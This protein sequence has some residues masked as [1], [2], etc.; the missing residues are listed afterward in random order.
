[1]GW[2]GTR[3]IGVALAITVAL[4]LT[5]PS[6][7]AEEIIVSDR[8]ALDAAKPAVP[9][10]L[11][12]P[13]EPEDEEVVLSE[14]GVIA[15]S[16]LYPAQFVDSGE[17]TEDFVDSP[18]ACGG[19]CCEPGCCPV[20]CKPSPGLIQF[21][22]HHSGARWTG[23]VEA[24]LLWRNAPANRAIFSEWNPETKTRGDSVIGAGD[25]ESTPAAGP[26]ISLFRHDCSGHTAEFTYF[27]AFNF[28]AQE[29]TAPSF[30]GYTIGPKG[31]Y[32]NKWT[33]LD[34][35]TVNLGSGLQSFEVN[36]RKCWTENVTLLAGLR[37]FEW[38][39]SVNILD[40]F[41]DPKLGFEDDLYNTRTMNSLYGGQIGFDA[42]LW[43]RGNWL[44]VDGLMKGGAYY[45]LATQ[46]SS[47]Q[48]G[49]TGT[50]SYAGRTGNQMDQAAFL[51]EVGLT[52]TIP[53]T[54]HVAFT[55]GYLGLWIEG[56]AQP[57]NQLSGQRIQ[58]VN[59]PP[60]KGSISAT[61]GTVVQGVTLGLNA[62]W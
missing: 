9:A 47:Y 8:P 29:A 44:R 3:T 14:D 5:G 18:H 6:A 53:L 31:I 36:E 26:R 38:R 50:P 54:D 23:R 30:G 42:R 34:A 57:T 1:M 25:L 40:R 49:P 58:Q 27:R 46:H 33:D 20:E 7:A 28:R 19:S 60:P 45:N 62:K 41:N 24:L 10:P 11:G 51:G 39:E 4:A 52:G 59:P 12:L 37:W 17:A 13:V 22:R 56:I 16:D 55:F 15:S 61:G 2:G 32:G 48:Y 35:G 43:D 21:F